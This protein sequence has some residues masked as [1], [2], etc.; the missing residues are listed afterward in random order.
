[1][2]CRLDQGIVA[3]LVGAVHQG[4]TPVV[5]PHTVSGE[6]CITCL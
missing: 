6:A 3:G 5:I 4:A 2:I 1:V